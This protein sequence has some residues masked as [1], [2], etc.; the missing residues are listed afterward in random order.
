MFGMPLRI[1]KYI[2][3]ICLSLPHASLPHS[4]DHPS[5]IKKRFF[6]VFVVMLISPFFI[7]LFSAPEV[8]K[9]YTIW[10]VMGLRKE[11]LLTA[12]ASPLLLT[13]ILFLG[14]LSV[15]LTNGIWKIYSGMLTRQLHETTWSQSLT[16][17]VACLLVIHRTN[18]LVKLLP[19]SVVVAQPHCRSVIRRIHIQSLHASVAAAV[20]FADD[21]YLHYAALLWCW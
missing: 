18:V 5:T 8:L 10:E 16:H 21:G 17:S 20:V 1:G 15:Q 2:C 9:N 4:S 11:G 6:S 12:F 14:P 3:T 13:M 19:E 7:Y